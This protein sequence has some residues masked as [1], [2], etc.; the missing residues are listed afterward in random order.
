MSRMFLFENW[1]L[2]ISS[3]ELYRHHGVDL[4]VTYISS[5]IT[6]LYRILKAY[7]AEGVLMLKPA[8]RFSK[9]VSVLGQTAYLT[10]VVRDCS[11]IW[12]T[13]RTSRTSVSACN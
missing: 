4:I 13:T 11:Q 1:Q 10:K 12:I 5:V 7:E 8:I 6:D 2:L 9:P 3:L